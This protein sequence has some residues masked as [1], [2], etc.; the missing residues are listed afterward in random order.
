MS[1]QS[2]HIVIVGAGAGA[3]GLT[4]AR[5]L[6]RAGRRVTILEA[7]ERCGGRIHPLSA[8][9]FGY[10]ADGGAEFVHGE[11]PVTRA[12][13][14]EAGLSLREIAGT[15]WSFDGMGLSRE[16]RHDLHGA[17]LQA[18][19]RVLK[20]DLP[21]ADFL[22]RHFAGADYAPLRQSI[23]RM[24]EG[25]DA[26]DPERASTLA[27]REEWMDGG[28]A[29]QARIEGGYGALIDVLAAECR[30]LGVA[31]R[32]G[33]TVSAIEEEG[34]AVAIRCA[35]DDGLAGD[36]AILTVPLPLLREIALPPSARARAAAADD[37]GFG[38]VIK[39][40]LRFTR[41]W[42]RDQGEY[43]ADM[44]FLLSEETIPV[45]WT[46]YPD[47]HPLLTGWFGGPRTAELS[48][49]DPQ[50]LIAAGLDSLAAIFK[51]PR[52]VIAH[53]LMASAAINWT[54]DPFARG[55]YSWATPRTRQAQAV[56]AR[57][58]GMILFSGEALYR[59][60]DMGTVEA[61]LA[62]GL[63]TAEMMLRR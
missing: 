57:A 9:Q 30:C 62:S 39:I 60:R 37:I 40:L 20:D 45:W 58:D 46:R 42:W 51:L 31:I 2:E 63:A 36:R 18:M 56:L 55:A 52:E 35:G 3:A 61:A 23:E 48:R 27:L 25:Y 50:G 43:L 13:L 49:L 38:N 17:E 32:L 4:A 7:R 44:T 5:E 26:A 1:Q 14:R 47:Q 53:D 22:R 28:H 8:S 24:V 29:P 41:P 15:Q 33:C 11:A 54:H 34:G 59:G 12:L 19:L 16:D 6:A 10:P 21:V